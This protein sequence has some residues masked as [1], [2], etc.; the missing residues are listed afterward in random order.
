M[1]KVQQSLIVPKSTY[2]RC[3]QYKNNKSRYYSVETCPMNLWYKKIS[4]WKARKWEFPVQNRFLFI[5]RVPFYSKELDLK[6]YFNI[7]FN[8]KYTSF[9]FFKTPVLFLKAMY[10]TVI[11]AF[12][13]ETSQWGMQTIR[14]AKELHPHSNSDFY[15]RFLI[16]Y[17]RWIWGYTTIRP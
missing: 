7:K 13:P 17:F 2:F 8:I 14:L 11:T 4:S 5:F 9:S 6:N 10:S 1:I 16:S 12:V 15:N 3:F